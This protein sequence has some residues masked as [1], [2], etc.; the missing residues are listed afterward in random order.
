MQR[1]AENASGEL[2]ETA[3]TGARDTVGKASTARMGRAW[4]FDRWFWLLS[5]LKKDPPWRLNHSLGRSLAGKGPGINMS[6]ALC[7]SFQNCY[8]I[9]RELRARNPVPLPHWRTCMQSV[10]FIQLHAT[11]I[12]RGSCRLSLSA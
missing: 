10:I 9:V 1:L 8:G 3:A 5:R 12:D 2:R 7:A 6:A 11:R 4:S